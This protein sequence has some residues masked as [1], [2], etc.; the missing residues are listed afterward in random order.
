MQK[1][2]NT[3][4][5]FKAIALVVGANLPFVAPHHI[6]RLFL[7]MGVASVLLKFWTRV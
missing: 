2:K 4:S 3:F 5:M 7:V 1:S 6:V